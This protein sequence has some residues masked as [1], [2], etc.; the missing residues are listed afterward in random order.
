M[1]S[2]FFLNFRD[3]NDNID[4]MMK[5]NPEILSISC[6][7]LLYR[8]IFVIVI[9]VNHF[10]KDDEVDT[11]RVWLNSIGVFVHVLVLIPLFFEK[12]KF[13]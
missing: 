9:L 1:K 12:V 5:R 4:Y 3:Q 7:L 13:W 2:L 8:I 6:F 10:A 11:R